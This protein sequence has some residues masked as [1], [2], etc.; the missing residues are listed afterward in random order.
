MVSTSIDVQAIKSRVDLGTL[1][2]QTTRLKRVATTRGGEWAGP[3]PFCGGR[4]RF[5]VQP[6]KG[7]WFCRQCSP[8]GRWQDAIAFI[9]KRE[10]VPFVEA[11]RMLGA[12][13]SE[14]GESIQQPRVAQPTL[15]LAEDV[16]PTASWRERANAF[17]EAC[18]A[19]LWTDAGARARTYLGSR[20]L[21]PDT[22]RVWRVGFH[23]ADRYD[24]P[25]L[26]GLP[27]RNSSGKPYR[28]WL[29]RGIVVPWYIGERLWLVKVRRATDDP[30][31]WAIRGGHPLLYGADTLVPGEP[32]V[33]FEGELD[34]L[35]AWQAVHDR[36]AT[37][38]LGS[39]SRRPTRR[40]ALLLAQAEPLLAAYDVE[41]EGDKGAE[42]LRQLEGSS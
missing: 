24:S 2:G 42:R 40:A 9:M 41:E 15:L 27:E 11:C 16:E 6:E 37:V 18:E 13:A 33:M 23:D 29:P 1:A 10:N 20:G 8:P 12:S 32:A 28:V 3:C 39:A 21:E 19:A 26:W 31:Y 38:S 17:V 34:T 36:A 4:D 25:G 30:K 5:R 22:L 7:L 35:L 14:M